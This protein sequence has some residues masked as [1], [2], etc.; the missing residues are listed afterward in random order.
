MVRQYKQAR[1]TKK[2][3]LTAAAKELE[4][5]QPALS[6]WESE[7]SSP[8]VESLVR[9]AELYGVTTDYLLGRE[10]IHAMPDN[11]KEQVPVAA[12]PVLHGHAAWS[13]KYGW[14]LIN[15]IE[16]AVIT[17][18]CGLVPYTDVGEIYLYPPAF[19][20]TYYN[21][22]PPITIS[23]LRAKSKVW[24]EPI[25]SDAQIR[26]ELRGWYQMKDWYIQNEYGNRF[27]LDT[28][29]SKWLAFNSEIEQ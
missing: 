27:Y 12:L 5:S 1:K 24:V 17:I 4:I 6:A 11:M 2:L 16:K 19:A 3:T 13:K 7:R 10:A 18:D 14:V 28:Y 22:S 9:M 20:Y 21:I 23:E 29:G 15:A 26:E 8:S 25:S